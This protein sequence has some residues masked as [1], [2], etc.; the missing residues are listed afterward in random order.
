MLV[1]NLVRSNI[2]IGNR[3]HA[4]KQI[5]D[6]FQICEIDNRLMNAYSPQLHCLLGTYCLS[7]NLKDKALT[8]FNQ[9]LKATQDSDLWLLNAM[10]SAVCYF[11]SLSSS[12]PTAKNQLLSIMENLMPENIQTQ[13]TSLTALSHYFRALKF[14]LNANYQEAK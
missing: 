6:L 11:S 2:S 4:I 5:G 1:E 9:S 13:N 12:N 14:Y 8:Q 10:N 3:C 7:M